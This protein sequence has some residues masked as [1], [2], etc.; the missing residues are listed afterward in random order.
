MQYRKWINIFFWG[1]GV[2]N[3]AG[4]YYSSSVED[5]FTK[6]FAPAAMVIVD[7]R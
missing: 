4:T 1:G 7:P 6:S 5:A 3:I 2:E